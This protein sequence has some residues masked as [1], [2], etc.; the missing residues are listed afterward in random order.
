MPPPRRDSLPAVGGGDRAAAGNLDL[1]GRCVGR[2]FQESENPARQGDGEA[3]QWGAGG[4]R[5]GTETSGVGPWFLLV[6]SVKGGF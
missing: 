1:G 5:G 2:L 3:V 6:C 4:A